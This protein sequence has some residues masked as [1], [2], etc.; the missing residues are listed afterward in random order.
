M[1]MLKLMVDNV[2]SQVISAS[3]LLLVGVVMFLCVPTGQKC[4]ISFW[5]SHANKTLDL[6]KLPAFIKRTQQEF[7]SL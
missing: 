6:V 2:W 5:L 1:S 4:Q 7:E 3:I